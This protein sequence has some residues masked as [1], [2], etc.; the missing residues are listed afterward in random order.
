V[1]ARERKVKKFGPVSGEFS[2][3]EFR[4]HWVGFGSDELPR[5]SVKRVETLSWA[6]GAVDAQLRPLDPPVR[7]ASG[8]V[9]SVT[10]EYVKAYMY[11]GCNGP[12]FVSEPLVDTS[13]NGQYVAVPRE[14]LAADYIFLGPEFVIPLGKKAVRVRQATI[15]S[16]AASKTAAGA[17]P[18]PLP[19][20]L[21]QSPRNFAAV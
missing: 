21:P 5:P 15:D 16:V 6:T 13:A 11:L 10:G 20:P 4:R 9:I 3:A 7:D 8:K 1:K 18:V 2:Q 17:T 19:P 12:M 14:F